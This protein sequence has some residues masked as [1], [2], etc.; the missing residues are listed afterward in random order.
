[1]SRTP[2]FYLLHEG[3]SSNAVERR[4]LIGAA[5]QRAGL[6][7]HPLDSLTCN[8]ADLP[9]PNTGDL[10]FNAT[11]GSTRL[12]TLLHRPDLATFRT[13]NAGAFTNGGDTTALCALLA[14]EGFPTPKTYHRLPAD[15]DNL[16]DIVSW[17]GGFPV[18]IKK[19]DGTL[20]I[21]AMLIESMRSLR[22]VLDY[23]RTTGEEFILR[24]YIKP[25]KIGRLLVLGDQVIASLSYRIPDDDFRSRPFR[26]GG[27]QEDFGKAVE[28]LAINAGKTCQHEF[29]GVDIIIDD[30]DTPYIL[31]VNAPSNFVAIERDIGIPV[32]DMIVEHLMAKSN[33]LRDISANV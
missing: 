33:Q 23:L 9:Q 10:L 1:M 27:M 4:D 6:H 3:A 21:G 17:L 13:C 25:K 7:F 32:S 29:T 28:R 24:E 19:L 11:R 20:G 8:Y 31:E 5:A 22:S 2:C 12:E 15:N 16:N 26:E 18:V 30:T 14:K